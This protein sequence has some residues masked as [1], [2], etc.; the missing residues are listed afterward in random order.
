MEN[1]RET[2]TKTNYN[3][4]MTYAE[5]LLYCLKCIVKDKCK[6]LIANA[7]K[8]HIWLDWWEIAW[9]HNGTHFHC[10]Y[11]CLMKK[12]TIWE[13]LCDRKHWF[14]L[15]WCIIQACCY[16]ESQSS[17]PCRKSTSCSSF[18]IYIFWLSHLS[19]TPADG[20]EMIGTSPLGMWMT[21][22][23]SNNP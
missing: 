9:F 1:K 14:F 19:I 13:L 5:S 4:D 12:C 20:W 15:A 10:T 3:V 17:K 6:S 7:N 23:M 11:F 16:E 2:K 18:Y 21:F 8:S 22:E